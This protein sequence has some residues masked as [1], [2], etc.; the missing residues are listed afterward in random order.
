MAL[1]VKVLSEADEQWLEAM[2]GKKWQR[3][4]RPHLAAQKRHFTLLDSSVDAFARLG[5]A[6]P[7]NCELLR[8][9]LALALSKDGT[10][11]A[12][13]RDRKADALKADGAWERLWSV[14]AGKI[15]ENYLRQRKG[16]VEVKPT[17]LFDTDVQKAVGELLQLAVQQGELSQQQG[18]EAGED[19]IHPAHEHDMV[20]QARAGLEE[21][22]AEEENVAHPVSDGEIP[23]GERETEIVKSAL[24][25]L[26]I[27]ELRRIAAKEQLPVLSDAEAISTLIARKYNAN[28]AEIAELILE[29]KKDDV[30]VGYATHLLPLR[31]APD[32]SFAAQRLGELRG[33]YLRLE[34][35][36][37]LVF[38]ESSGITSSTT[39]NTVEFS[40]ELRYYAVAPQREGE[41]SEITAKQRNVAITVRLG[42]N[43]PWVEVDG[44]NLTEIRRIRPALHKGLGVPTTEAIT[45]NVPSLQGEAAQWD[46]ATLLMLHILESGLRDEHIEYANFT[47]AHFSAPNQNEEEADPLR[48]AIKQ[49]TLSGTHVLSSPDACRL[50]AAGQEMLRIEFRARYRPIAGQ[51]GYHASV[52]ISVESEHASVQTSYGEDRVMSKALHKELVRR[53][54]RAIDNGVS[55]A[56]ELEHIIEQI[57]QRAGQAGDAETADILGPGMTAAKS[58]AMEDGAGD[59]LAGVTGG[60]AAGAAR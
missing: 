39:T 36:H 60:Q 41:I 6:D 53:L 46:R 24:L 21:T 7:L 50:I 30:E 19:F 43:V 2:G 8:N 17:L 11:G 52:R 18:R 27:S 37:W 29:H 13:F 15:V 51:E 45:L 12:E 34:V 33:R 26:K 22:L 32:L 49:V 58:D 31:A 59:G 14:C 47:S 40:G 16:P 48:P 44:R 25:K 23:E 1:S 55:N 56:R 9:L 5:V 35:A 4:T 10:F 20:A 57:A 42:Q 54:R 38:G 3:K 28:R